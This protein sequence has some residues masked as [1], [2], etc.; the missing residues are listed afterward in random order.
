M[1][2]IDK[3][4]KPFETMDKASDAKEAVEESTQKSS[5]S[6][7]ATVDKSAK[8]ASTEKTASKATGSKKKEKVALKDVSGM[9][10]RVIVRPLQTEKIAEHMAMGQ[11]VFEVTEGATKNEVKKAVK[12]MYNV[13]PVKVRMINVRGKMV[14]FGRTYAKRKNWRKAIVSLKQ[15]DSIEVFEGV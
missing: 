2:L 13:D 1:S 3:F 5:T 14:R 7:K 12:A 15:G 11:Y 8:K 9:A 4:K 6:A 10:A